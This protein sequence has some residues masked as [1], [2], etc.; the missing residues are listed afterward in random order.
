MLVTEPDEVTLVGWTA[1]PRRG[2]GFILPL[3]RRPGANTYIAQEIGADDR[4]VGFREID[5]KSVT[6]I[7]GE[8]A[9]VI[10]ARGDAA[11]W[12]YVFPHDEAQLGE[13]DVLAAW[14]AE[15]VDTIEE[16]LLQQQAVEYCEVGPRMEDSWRAA[17]ARLADQSLRSAEAWRDVVVV[18]TRV[19]YAVHRAMLNHLLDVS[20]V[21]L[22][23]LVD[24]SVDAGE[25][26]VAIE[27]ELHTRLSM[28]PGALDEI[29]HS[30]TSM[31]NAFGFGRGLSTFRRDEPG[32]SSPFAN[33]RRPPA[34]V[35]DIKGPT[36]AMSFLDVYLQRERDWPRAL[37]RYSLFRMPTYRRLHESMLDAV[38]SHGRHGIESEEEFDTVLRH[39]AAQVARQLSGSRQKVGSEW[40]APNYGRNQLRHALTGDPMRFD[41]AVVT[42]LA[43]NKLA[44]K[45]ELAEAFTFAPHGIVA[46]GFYFANL[47][48]LI[49]RFEGAR[50]ESSEAF[51]RGVETIAS[52]IDQ[53]PVVLRLL[54][55][56]RA[57][58]QRTQDTMR[59][60]THLASYPT[61]FAI[62]NALAT[63]LPDLADVIDNDN[64]VERIIVRRRVGMQITKIINDE[65]LE[66]MR[67]NVGPYRWPAD[68][69]PERG[70]WPS[71]L[72]HKREIRF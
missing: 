65:M 2:P 28:Q 57:E 58:G 69:F 60:A 17:F 20:E 70:K 35:D 49:E 54:A 5:P 3:F 39:E 50:D 38:I 67:V 51:D 48:R 11:I 37:T 36:D 23:R 15:R 13:R 31:R 24:V 21:D 71:G 68:G 30:T 52:M 72:P 16:P 8:T 26:R 62:L 43:F 14:L 29:S 63:R 18:P 10:R 4:I 12:G 42:V 6:E 34:I 19:R 25:V 56:Y 45:F 32:S 27:Q 40:V 55:G 1:P 22:G 9:D 53:P 47:Y 44:E 66:P 41:K 64:H 59:A 46:C 61:Q 7:N 33:S